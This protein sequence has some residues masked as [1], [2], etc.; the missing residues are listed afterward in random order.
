MR[1]FLL[2]LL[3]CVLFSATGA[4][5]GEEYIEHPV[6]RAAPLTPVALQDLPKVGGIMVFGATRG[7][8]LEIVKRLAEREQKVTVMARATSDL[9]ELQKLN[10]SIVVGDAF[11]PDDIKSAFATAPFL[12]A[13]SAV[14]GGREELPKPDFEANKNIIDAAKVAKVER[15]ILIS[16]IGAGDS[17]G[18]EPWLTRKLI[19]DTLIL[20]TQAEDY[21]KVSGLPYL[22]VRPGPLTDDPP[23][24]TA[25][26]VEDPKRVGFVSRQDL[27]PMVANATIDQTELNKTYSAVD[28]TREGQWE[29]WKAAIKMAWARL[30]ASI[31]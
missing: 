8:G 13:I 22:I 17:A 6:P 19:G 25:V 23:A 24:G 18:V 14:G 5:A 10:V 29:W 27:G 16:S 31:I 20:K 15:F 4:R 21:L 1:H 26:M 3:S 9:T 30:I 11:N 2:L 7:L 28:T 12:T